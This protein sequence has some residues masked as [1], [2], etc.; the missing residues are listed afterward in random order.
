MILEIQATKAEIL[1]LYLNDVYLGHRGSFAL[2]GVAEASK[3]YFGKDVRNLTLS[4]AALIAGIIQSPSNHSPFTNV[5]SGARPAQRG[6]AR[7]GRRR[8][9]HQ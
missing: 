6:A 5:R 3:I 8:V 7:D 9:H 4:E 2:H 1:E